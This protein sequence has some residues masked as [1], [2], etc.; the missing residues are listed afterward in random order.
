MGTL[1]SPMRGAAV[2]MPAARRC[3]ARTAFAVLEE[4][5]SIV[6]TGDDVEKDVVGGQGASR[7]AQIYGVP[8]REFSRPE[9]QS[10][11]CSFNC[12]R[13]VPAF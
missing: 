13:S 3:S 12:C 2:A 5:L 11:Y 9:N 7:K 8:A 4:R 1:V 6:R 10:Q